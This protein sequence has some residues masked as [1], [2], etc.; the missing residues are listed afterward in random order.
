MMQRRENR[1]SARPFQAAPLMVVDEETDEDHEHKESRTR[2]FFRAI[3]FGCFMSKRKSADNSSDKSTP[4]RAIAIEDVRY[5][6]DRNVLE[7]E[8]GSVYSSHYGG[9]EYILYLGT[10][11]ETNYKPSYE[12]KLSE[13]QTMDLTELRPSMSERQLPVFFTPPP[14]DIVASVTPRRKKVQASVSPRG[15]PQANFA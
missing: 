3:G 4:L 14:P 6:F 15:T 10:E 11:H 8:V 7:S 1:R 5:G 12:R 13:S 9:N 2:R